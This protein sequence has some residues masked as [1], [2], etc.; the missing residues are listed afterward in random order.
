MIQRVKY[1]VVEAIHPMTGRDRRLSYTK[2][3]QVAI[4]ALYALKVALP[5]AV[6]ISVLAAS[7]GVK[8]FMA[9]VNRV[10]LVQNANEAIAISHS[11][12]HVTEKRE[13]VE[14]RDPNAGIEPTVKPLELADAD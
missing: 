3:M 12:S 1:L 2:F 4:L 8:A 5:V 6:A 9:W 10:T 14:R 7:F 11:T 13:I